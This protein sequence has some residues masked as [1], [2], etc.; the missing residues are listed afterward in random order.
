M[1]RG[2]GGER[3]RLLA[4]GVLLAACGPTGGAPEV[5]RPEMTGAEP[6]VIEA[7]DAAREAVRQDPTS[8]ETW[9]R[10][11]NRLSV[12]DFRAEAL[13]CY[14]RAEQLRP[15]EFSWPYLLGLTLQKADPERAA[16]VLSRAL[17]LD[18]GYAPAHV[19][20][21]ETLVHLGRFDEAR[22]HFERARRLDPDN[23]YAEAGLGQLDLSAGR[24]EAAR[25]HLERATRLDPRHKE[26]HQSLAQVYLA[27]GDPERAREH[28]EL[29]H[30]LPD[31][32]RMPDPRLRAQRPEPVGSKAHSELGE[33]LQRAGKLE[34]AIP[35]FRE[36]LRIKPES[37]VAHY[38]LGTI[39]LRQG[40]TGE[41]LEHLSQAVRLRP[42]MAMAHVNLGTALMGLGR[43]DEAAA[44]FREAL[45]T[46]PD[47]A[48]AHY[49]LGSL[50]ASVG[51]RLDEAEAHFRDAAR[52]AP[53]DPQPQWAL[54]GV[55][56]A[57]GNAAGAVRHY[58][59]ALRLRPDWP[60]P[61][62]RL[63]WIQA[64]HPDAGLRDGVEAVRLGEMV[65]RARGYGDPAALDA[66]A[67]AY[68]EVGRYDDAVEAAQRAVSV[69]SSAGQP[70][71]AGQVR[72]RLEL[73]RSR[74]PFRD[75]DR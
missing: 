48:D 47:D 14:E 66:L 71:L 65:C 18:E 60:L 21:A 57:R 3:L 32:T 40:K 5:P 61:A 15:D 12:H 38:N 37:A 51:G 23:P 43:E 33:A 64:T 20:Y 28:A 10:L 13:R 17:A 69:A 49:N 34:E 1:R 16:E 30:D 67:A 70:A 58:R 55:L 31:R 22:R 25:E 72:S 19:H 73:Y 36:A 44:H 41:A 59:E 24:I 29:T 56:Q 27:L 2:P 75:D 4:L 39:L 53:D 11:G 46:K 6:E 42:H 35:H 7:V 68:A 62:L 63:A 9:G 54:G 74:R 26:A 52:S 45:R 8:A 50:L